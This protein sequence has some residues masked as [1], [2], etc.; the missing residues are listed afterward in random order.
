MTIG[1]E[2]SPKLLRHLNKINIEKISISDMIEDAIINYYNINIIDLNESDE[3]LYMNDKLLYVLN[4]NKTHKICAD[5]LGIS[6]RTL[7][8]KIKKLNIIKDSFGIYCIK[9]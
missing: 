9:I 8:R 4:N 1:F 7:H 2:C 3:N 6:V 5:I